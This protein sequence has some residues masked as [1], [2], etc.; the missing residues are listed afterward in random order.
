[1]T[2]RS[3]VVAMSLVVVAC[4]PQVHGGDELE[5][6]PDDLSVFQGLGGAPAALST[7]FTWQGQQTGYWCGPASTRIALSARMSPPS[8]QTL[9]NYEGT[10]TNGTDTIVYVRNA[11]NHYLGVSHYVNRAISDP[12]SQGQIDAL[13]QTI[14]ASVSNGYGM[15]GNIISGW[16]PP[17]YPSG[18][19]YHYVAIVGYDQDGNRALIA[20]PAAK[21]A[22][23]SRWCNVP[24]TYWVSLSN[25]A[26][27]IG[28]STGY[29]G[30]SLPIKADTAPGTGTLT[31]AIYEKGASAN[32]VA[33]AVV[34]VGGKSV[35]TGADGLYTFALAPGAYTATVTKAGY[36][37]NSVSRTV[38]S[39][40]TIWGS[41]EINAA[42]ATGTLKGKIYAYNAA[43]PADMSVVIAGASVT[44]GGQS[45]T[46]GADGL[47]SFTLPAGTYAVSVTKAGYASNSVSRA[48]TAGQ[49][50]WGSVGL[51]N[52]SSPDVQPPQLAIAFPADKAQLELGVLNLEGTASDDRGPLAAV[53]LSLNG[54]AAVEVPVTGGKFSVE[55]HLAPGD[56]VFK[57]SAKDAAGNA[58]ATS[59]TATFHA[60]VGGAIGVDG[61]P[62]AKV[63]AA[64]VALIDKVSGATIGTGVFDPATGRYGLELATVPVEGILVVSAEGFTTSREELT[65]PADRRLGHDVALVKGID[66]N[67]TQNAVSI[68]SPFAN[69]VIAADSVVVKGIATGFEAR[70]VTVNGV[71]AEVQPSGAFE[72]TVPL[73]VGP[74]TLEA[75]AEGTLGEHARSAVTVT[76]RESGTQAPQ[77]PGTP[78]KQ[79]CSALA[80]GAELMALAAL[81]PLL[82]RRSRG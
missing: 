41:M 25:L 57:L 49:V 65:I 18:T 12:P 40:Q 59:S 56:N 35:T 75:V 38:A 67:G 34:T 79:G 9:A 10:T 63:G 62:A 52:A 22:A 53:Q 80:S 37:T 5:P 70:A 16:R 6:G 44:A 27:W 24:S 36:G 48:V 74:N 71:A 11:M 64:S 69:A 29:T 14:V 2:I 60:G 66:E 3:M 32:R 72:V 13:R 77:D 50:I 81:L 51:S 20:D 26:T 17:G 4:G 68:L 23:G 31:G 58:G 1:M 47:Y 15:V 30:S 76:R 82:R 39:G 42:A 45:A 55:V 8:Q 78:A 33:G 46:T 28:G 7:N 19:I 21:C 54:G 43:N 61:E 73:A